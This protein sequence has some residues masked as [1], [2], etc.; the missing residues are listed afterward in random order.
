MRSTQKSRTKWMKL[1]SSVTCSMGSQEVLS[2]HINEL[3]GFD[4]TSAPAGVRL[5]RFE[6]ADRSVRRPHRAER[7]IGCARRPFATAAHHRP[8]KGS[9]PPLTIE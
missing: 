5:V 2:G 9:W 6:R 3:F 8:H 1:P 4:S 7:A